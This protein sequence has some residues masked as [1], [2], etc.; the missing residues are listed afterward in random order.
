MD[1]VD[2]I[3]KGFLC[4]LFVSFI[5]ELFPCRANP[6]YGF[7]F[8]PLTK[9][10]FKLQK[11]YNE[12]LADR[13][14]YVD[15]VRRFWIYNHDKSFQTDSTTRPRIEV[16]IAVHLSFYDHSISYHK[17]IDCLNDKHLI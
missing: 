8:V 9:E 15:R 17:F 16:R 14:T 7:I 2:Y 10:N 3:Y 4:L 13:Y 1:S 11:P 12:P 6:T 5:T